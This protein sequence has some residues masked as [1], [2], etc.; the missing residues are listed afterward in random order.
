MIDGGM[1]SFVIFFFFA[2]VAK[3]KTLPAETVKADIK[4]SD[5]GEV[6]D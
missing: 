1:F 5:V 6:K 2:V 3:I 4:T